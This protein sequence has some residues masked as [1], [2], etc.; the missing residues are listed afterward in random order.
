MPTLNLPY[1]SSEP[2]PVS[3]MH[4][5]C[6]PCSEVLRISS[7]SARAPRNWTSRPEPVVQEAELL[8]TSILF[9]VFVFFVP[10][11]PC[12]PA[13]RLARNICHSLCD[14]AL[15]CWPRWGPLTRQ[16]GSLKEK[17]SPLQA[18]VLFLRRCD[19]VHGCFY[20]LGALLLASS[21]YEPCYL[22]ST[23]GP[24]GCWKLPYSR[25][26]C[27]LLRRSGRI[28]KGFVPQATQGVDGLV[29]GMGP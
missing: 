23:L 13:S 15:A 21:K 18:C 3:P 20:T 4:I 8:L 27:N 29:D 28:Q 14:W 11:S 19:L 2:T 12:R 7:S 24:F 5:R 22:G 26:G 1:T 10:L 6:R 25:G 9:G 16:A 17:D